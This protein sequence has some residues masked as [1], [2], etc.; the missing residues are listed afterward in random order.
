MVGIGGHDVLALTEDPLAFDIL[1]KESQLSLMM[2]LHLTPQGTTFR[3]GQPYSGQASP[4]RIVS[5]V[6]LGS[7]GVRVVI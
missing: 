3:A 6:T 7:M 2:G 5:R 4:P 1:W